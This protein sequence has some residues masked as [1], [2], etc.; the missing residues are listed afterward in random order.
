MDKG[1]LYLVA[2]PVGN[3]EDI[4]LR[5]LRVLKEV[6]L[7]ACEDTRRTF[8]LLQHYEINTPRES[9]HKF[10]EFSQI[11]R[12]VRM[13][14][15]GKKIALVSDSG[16][17]LI[18]DPGY[19]LVSA[20]RKEGI[21]VVP[22]PGPSAAVAALVGSGFPA[23]SF[24]FAGFLP[25]KA[26]QRKRRLTELAG[27]HA[28]LV[29]FEAPH[30]IL[31]SLKDMADILGERKA[32]IAR[33]ITKI[34]EEFL[35]GTIPELLRTLQT[36]ARIKGEFTIIVGPAEEI[37]PPNIR[38]DSIQQHLAEEMQRSGLARKEALKAVAKQRGITKREAY[39]LLLDE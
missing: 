21:P 33:E 24:F 8:K 13:L 26:T 2:T 14:H 9:Y 16:T 37:V 29:F 27:I 32:C 4:T 28:T 36:R 23:E 22:V 25:A 5:A 3:L 17:P 11:P 15:E 35:L 39:K 30:R 6:D 10:N 38:T 19:E 31:S 34:H 1:T 18:S 7:I 20:C 12:L